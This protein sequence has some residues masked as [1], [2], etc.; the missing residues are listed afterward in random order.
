MTKR[1]AAIVL[2]FLIASIRHALAE[3]AGKGKVDRPKELEAKVDAYFAPFLASRDFAG[4]VLI[5]QGDNVVLRKAYGMANCEWAVSNTVDTKFAIASLTKTFTAAAIVLLQERGLLS[6]SDRLNKY[7]PDYPK[8]EK[9]SIQHLLLH[10]GGIPNPDEASIFHEELPLDRL[11]DA[12]KNKPLDFEPGTKS[13]YSSAGYILLAR[14][15]EK[16]SGQQFNEFLKANIFAPLGMADTGGLEQ[17]PILA[18]RAHG[19]VAG[20]GSAGLENCPVQ[21]SWTGSGSLYSTVDDLFRWAQ[22]V[23]K[24]QLYKRSALKY[25]YGW[26]KRKQFGHVYIEQSGLVPGFASKL[27]LL[28]DEPVTIVWLSNIES[29]LF[30]RV[31]KDLIALAFGQEPEK[32]QAPTPGIKALNQRSFN[33]LLGIYQGPGFRLR[34]IQD[35]ANLFGKFDEGPWRALLQPVADDEL[36]MRT[37]FAKMRVSRDKNGQ[38]TQLHIL[39]GGEGDPM[40]LNR[41]STADR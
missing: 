17:A 25:A 26:G 28:F 13:E 9:I 10:A 29:G 32:Y 41:V 16:A 33:G 22:A 38:A 5:A 23:R 37:R 3:D 40:I 19:Y 36:Y 14:I 39:W 11:I 15:V 2:L 6:Y 21:G 7:L 8:G 35:K 12:F 27:I 30:G 20:P 1:T 31:E 34:I 18:K 24:E 4:V